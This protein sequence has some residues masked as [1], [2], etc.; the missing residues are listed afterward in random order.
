MSGEPLVRLTR[1]LEQ[2]SFATTLGGEVGRNEDIAVYE[3]V[4]SGDRPVAPGTRAR[5]LL[6]TNVVNHVLPLIRYELTDEITMLDEPNPGPWTGRH[7]ADIEGRSDDVFGYDRVEV[8]P[9]V[10][11][12]ARPSPRGGIVRRPQTG[13]D[14]TLRYSVPVDTMRSPTSSWT[15]LLRSAS[16]RRTCE[17]PSSRPSPDRATPGRY[18]HS[19]PSPAGRRGHRTRRGGWRAH[20]VQSGMPPRASG[21]PSA[22]SSR[23]PVPS[24][25]TT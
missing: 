17:C 19:C 1:R 9:Y 22:R 4:D 23:R 25:R 5:K 2:V 16:K 12:R 15:V 7:I 24:G 21:N 3:P 18:G 13:A 8:H 11:G 10:F 14:I 6:V 20:L